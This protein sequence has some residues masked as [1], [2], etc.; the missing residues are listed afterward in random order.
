M[1]PKHY[2]KYIL[3]Y[4]EIIYKYSLECFC[5]LYP[6]ESVRLKMYFLFIFLQSYE[7]MV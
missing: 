2:N 5:T 7:K 4:S 3:L 6:T 1:S